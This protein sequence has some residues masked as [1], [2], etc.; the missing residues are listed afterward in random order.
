MSFDTTFDYTGQSDQIKNNITYFQNL[1]SEIDNQIACF[2]M[3]VGYVDIKEN[4][5][6]ELNRLRN[7]YDG[8]LTNNSSA[9]QNISNLQALSSEDKDKLYNFL[10]YTTSSVSNYMGIIAT[11]YADM[12]NDSDLLMLIA[13]TTNTEETKNMIGNI[14]IQRFN[15]NQYYKFLN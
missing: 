7:I 1:L 12:L 15:K 8:E 14:I 9:L 6:A 11:C 13:D 10:Q 3:C 2:D 5:L 4:K